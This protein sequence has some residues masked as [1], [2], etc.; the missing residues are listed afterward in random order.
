MVNFFVF[1][2][3]LVL[4]AQQIHAD[5]T[6]SS[7]GSAAANTDTVDSSNNGVA[8][9]GGQKK[10]E[11]FLIS[12]T[13]LF[14]FITV[15]VFCQLYRRYNP[16]PDDEEIDY[17]RYP[18]SLSMMPQHQ[19]ESLRR[20][21]AAAAAATAE[22]SR[23]FLNPM[24]IDLIYPRHV[25]VEKQHKVPMDNGAADIKDVNTK[26]TLT[27]LPGE[28]ASEASCQPAPRDPV[29]QP[30]VIDVPS[31]DDDQ[32]SQSADTDHPEKKSLH[33]LF[34]EN[35]VQTCIICLEDFLHEQSVIRELECKH[36]YHA[37]CIDSWLSRNQICPLC[38]TPC[39][40]PESDREDTN[41]AQEEQPTTTVIITTQPSHSSLA[42]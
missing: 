2:L 35:C 6:S 34:V 17:T 37:D 12:A 9:G 14:I 10:W 23:T 27:E 42:L 30:A 8:L 3:C 5:P 38:K 7:T 18:Y 28:N 16:E 19:L 4:A 40:L 1:G 15:L 39:V 33:S 13:I 25:F 22:P 24:K 26:A 29:D 31:D 21:Q 36:I 20:R 41:E 11:Y 32:P